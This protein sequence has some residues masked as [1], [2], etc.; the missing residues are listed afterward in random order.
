MVPYGSTWSHMVPY[1]PQWSRKV[2]FSPIWSPMDTYGPLLYLPYR[3]VP[4]C[5]AWS[6]MVPWGPIWSPRVSYGPKS[7]LTIQFSWPKSNTISFHV[8]HFQPSLSAVIISALLL[9]FSSFWWVSRI[10]SL[11]VDFFYK[12]KYFIKSFQEFSKSV[13]ISLF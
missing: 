12:L 7:S 4:H 10:M 3:M 8:L 2:P 1:G 9:I 13:A 6:C 11:S 5:P